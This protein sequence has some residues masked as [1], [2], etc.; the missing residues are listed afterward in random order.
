MRLRWACTKN[1]DLLSSTAIG[2]ASKTRISRIASESSM[3]TIE[4]GDRLGITFLNRQ[5][6][7]VERGEGIYS[8]DE[9][10]KQYLDFTSIWAVTC[11]GHAHPVITAKAG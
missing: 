5:A 3:S 1:W 2:T 11:L 7:A 4:I 8:G 10:G 6:I 9:T